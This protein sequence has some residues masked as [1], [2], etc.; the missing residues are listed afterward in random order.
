MILVEYL[1]RGI[2]HPRSSRFIW[3]QSVFGRGQHL[4]PKIEELRCRKIVMV[5]RAVL[6]IVARVLIG[7]C[8]RM[9]RRDVI[10]RVIEMMRC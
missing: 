6:S 5:T 10:F 3:C 2:F 4:A 8:E 1:G 7:W 9:P